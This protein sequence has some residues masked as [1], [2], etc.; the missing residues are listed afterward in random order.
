LYNIPTAQ[1]WKIDTPRADE[2]HDF[3]RKQLPTLVLFFLSLLGIFL[4][5][6]SGLILP[7]AYTPTPSLLPPTETATIQWFP[8]TRTPTVFIAP[9]AT[10]TLNP[11]P[12]VGELLF[13]DDFSDPALWDVASSGDASAQ[14]AEGALT[15]AVNDDRLTI[16][17]LRTDPNLVDFYAEVTIKTSLCRGEDQ[18]GAV[19]RA[20]AGGNYY[21]FLLSCSGQVR[22]E[23]VRN[24]SVEVLQN[25][26]P[27]SDVPRGAPAEVKLGIWMSGTEMHL[28]LNDHA[29][30]IMRDPVFPIGRLGFFAYASGDTPVIVSF[31]DLQV[32]AVPLIPPTPA[33]TV[34]P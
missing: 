5:G 4:A 28:L 17:S 20:A 23:R 18:Y 1:G 21:R 33:F 3:M 9:T 26:A 31:R 15:L 25:W 11:L 34:T 6:C 24:G 27:S 8:P 2:G 14:V 16:T 30:F 22:L 19:F 32:Y 29:Q 10:A 7:E 13:T 12:A